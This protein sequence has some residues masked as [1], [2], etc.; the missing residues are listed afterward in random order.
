[1]EVK[2]NGDPVSGLAKVAFVDRWPSYRAACIDRFHCIN[3]SRNRCI[4]NIL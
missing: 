4:Y 1:M 2:M 3:I